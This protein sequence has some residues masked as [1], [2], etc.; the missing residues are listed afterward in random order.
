MGGREVQGA[1][2][3]GLESDEK[4]GSWERRRGVGKFQRYNP[5]EIG[6]DVWTENS[7]SRRE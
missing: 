5:T 6:G 4:S 2:K 7:W 1:D 3:G